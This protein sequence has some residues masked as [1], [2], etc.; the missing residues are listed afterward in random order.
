[1]LLSEH[2]KIEGSLAL[3]NRKS[4]GYLHRTIFVEL[5]M[6]VFSELIR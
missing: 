5:N 1:M 6:K 3:P 2:T 4:K